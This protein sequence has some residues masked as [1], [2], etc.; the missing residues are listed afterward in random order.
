MKE[1]EA[2]N[3]SL[4]KESST[5][6]KDL[7]V[8]YQEWIQEA[9]GTAGTLIP[10][11]GPVFKEKGIRLN[12]IKRQLD[13]L[14]KRNSALIA[15][16]EKEIARLK[17]DRDRRIREATAAKQRADGFLARLD[18]FSRLSGSSWAMSMASWFITFLF[19]A[20][21]TAPVAVKLLS[22]LSPYRT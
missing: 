4:K 19:I 22:T 1:L 11:R 3:Q 18:A 6:Q 14:E 15:Q 8:V 9:E 10:G 2:R 17:E 20:L 7:D 5:K 13:S 21:E 16:N 12:E